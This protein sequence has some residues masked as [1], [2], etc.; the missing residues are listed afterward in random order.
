M[1][2]HMTPGKEPPPP[3]TWPE[4]QLAIAAASTPGWAVNLVAEPGLGDHRKQDGRIEVLHH[5]KLLNATAWYYCAE[6]EN[7]RPKDSVPATGQ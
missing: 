1:G 7:R 5:V 4:R 2:L 3:A 6:T